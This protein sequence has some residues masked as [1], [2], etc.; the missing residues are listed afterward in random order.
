M[1]PAPG[2]NATRAPTISMEL[3]DV[4]VTCWFRYAYVANSRL[5]VING[6]LSRR[7]RIIERP[8]R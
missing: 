3:E 7:T 8:A 6:L 4:G 5:T 2:D 1:N